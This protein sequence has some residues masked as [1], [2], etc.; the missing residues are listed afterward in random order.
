MKMPKKQRT[1][2]MATRTQV[3][4]GD[5]RSCLRGERDKM[6]FLTN[7]CL[8]GEQWACYEIEEEYPVATKR[9]L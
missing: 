7:S 8:D 9:C 4:A 5:F 2:G 6:Q 3:N 1:L